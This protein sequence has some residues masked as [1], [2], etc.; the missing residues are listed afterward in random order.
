M[1]QDIEAVLEHAQTVVIGNKD[2]DFMDVPK[3]IRP[4]QRLVDLVR[5]S[6]QRSGNGNYSGICW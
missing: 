4:D 2:P 3:K 6:A 1:V 5:I